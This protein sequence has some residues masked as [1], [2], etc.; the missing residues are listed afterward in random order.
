[1]SLSLNRFNLTRK[2]LMVGTAALSL[3]FFGTASAADV[4][5]QAVGKD[6][7]Q[8]QSALASKDYAKAM[9]AV[10]AADAVKGKT[11]YEAYTTAQMRAAVAA[12]SGNT[13]AAI[14]AYDVLIASGR[15]PAAAKGQMLM[16]EATMAYSGKNYP[17]AIQ[18]TQRYLKDHALDTRMQTVLIQ[19]YYL[20]GDWKGC[21]QAAQAQ[22]DATIAAGKIP[23]ENHL[24]MLATAYTSLKDAD[25]KT[26]T[27]VLLAKYYNK[28]DY[29]AMLIHDLVANPNLQ[30]PLVL[31]V[32]RLRLQTGVLKDPSDFQD[33]GERAVQMGLSQLALNLLNQGYAAKILGV[34]PSAPAT[35][36]FHAFVAQR[37]AADRAQLTQDTAAAQAATNAGPSLT[38]GYNLVL[39]GQGP[40]GLALM[41]AGLAKSP[42]Y[43]D[44]A[45]VEYGMAQ[46]DA[47]Q[48]AEAVT[49]FNSIKNPGPARDVAALWAL[50]LSQPGH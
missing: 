42:R 39:N 21:A 40:A 19:S 12:Q 8:A 16:A 28:P 4:L 10:D 36:K 1:M 32:E 26:H 48:K 14:K 45:V 11:E 3:A 41:K 18:A 13:A 38:T 6:L 25:A 31:Y 2:T 24:Q 35:A 29:W 9:T 33:M 22:V 20:Q 50:L 43:P 17:L 37:A 15:T 47:G 5:G 27:Y 7:Q 49:T 30:P 46:M 34:G 23:P 44:L